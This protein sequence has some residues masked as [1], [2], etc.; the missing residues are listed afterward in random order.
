ME[1]TNV[2]ALAGIIATNIMT[3]ITLYIHLDGK[4]DRTLKAI[5]EEMK[6][7]H[8]RLIKQDADFQGKLVK[9]DADFKSSILLLEE[10]MRSI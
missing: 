1:I 4:T 5:Q 10:K 2:V 8:G 9:Q 6:D 3:I 7:F